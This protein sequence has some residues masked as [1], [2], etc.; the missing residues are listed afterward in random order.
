MKRIITLTALLFVLLNA[1]SFSQPFEGVKEIT[2]NQEG[3]TEYLQNISYAKPLTLQQ[4]EESTDILPELA[5]QRITILGMVEPEEETEFF[6]RGRLITQRSLKPGVKQANFGPELPFVVENAVQ[7]KAHE[8]YQI[9]G[10]LKQKDGQFFVDA[11]YAES[12]GELSKLIYF[13]DLS[14]QVATYPEFYWDSLDNL[15]D[16]LGELIASSATDLP[17][18][19]SIAVLA[20]QPVKLEAWFIDLD[21]KNRTSASGTMLISIHNRLSDSCAHCGS[22][23]EYGYD[24]TAKITLLEPL[25]SEVQ[26]GIFAGILR[27]NK[28]EERNQAGFFTIEDA[29]LVRPLMVPDKPDFNRA[30]RMKKQ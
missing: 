28:N 16:L 13:P 18:P 8:V 6:T 29:V 2:M 17:L 25:S 20:D 5:G 4:L 27:V 10:I 24:N 21:S 14:A 30:P 9:T 11:Q 3:Y 22:S 12:Q 7:F 19:K 1:Q 15:R 23:D 26:G